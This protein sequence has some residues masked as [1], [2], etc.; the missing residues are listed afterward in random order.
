MVEDLSHC[1][2]EARRAFDERRVAGNNGPVIGFL[3]DGVDQPQKVTAIGA[4]DD[5]DPLGD[6]VS[7]TVSTSSRKGRGRLRVA[8]SKVEF[9]NGHVIVASELGYPVDKRI[10]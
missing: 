2:R 4:V 10:L 3:S 6:L 9:A 5:I 7:A 8:Q 1:G